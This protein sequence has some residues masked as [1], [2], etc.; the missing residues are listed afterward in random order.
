MVRYKDVIDF[1]SDAFDGSDLQTPLFVVQAGFTEPFCDLSQMLKEALRVYIQPTQSASGKG[2]LP[3][4]NSIVDLVRV[5]AQLYCSEEEALAA[6]TGLPVIFSDFKLPAD[7]T[8]LF[9]TRVFTDP[10]RSISE[11]HLI[12]RWFDQNK[13]TKYF[14]EATYE[15]QKYRRVVPKRPTLARAASWISTVTRLHG[16]EELTFVEDERQVISGFRSTVDLP[17]SHVIIEIEPVFPNLHPAECLV[18]PILSRT[19]LRLFWTFNRYEYSGWE[20]RVRVG[21]LEWAT[22][23]AA[24]KDHAAVE[25]TCQTIKQAFAGFVEE[26]IRLRWGRTE[27]QMNADVLTSEV[28]ANAPKAETEQP[29]PERTQAAPRSQ[30]RSCRPDDAS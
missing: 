5:D 6:L 22:D 21:K 9:N 23:E 19:H 11:R 12:G 26:P 28:P 10:S 7:M 24:L 4:S 20:T 18:V 2:L 25:R 27:G 13:D 1:V 30:G 16:D 29:A 8:A 17:Y 14:V 3:E 15:I